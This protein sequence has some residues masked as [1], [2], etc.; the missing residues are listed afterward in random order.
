MKAGGTQEKTEAVEAIV[1]YLQ[2]VR[3]LC[4]D[5]GTSTLSTWQTVAV[6]V[7]G[8]GLPSLYIHR[9]PGALINAIDT[10]FAQI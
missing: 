4:G 7:A 6:H 2:N 1:S 10:T 5:P 8:P 9:L 3:K